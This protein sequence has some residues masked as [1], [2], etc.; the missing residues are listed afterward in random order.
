MNSSEPR[1]IW[2]SKLSFVLATAGAA[3]GLG[4]LWRFP[5]VAGEN[6][7]GAFVL[8]YIAFVVLLGVP[9]MMA[10]LAIGRRGGGS[11]V[12]S[13]RRLI[14]EEN[15]S[16]GWLAI[17]WLSLAVPLVGLSY[18]SVVA[19][20]SID[21]IAKAALNH[22]QQFNATDS[23]ASF[24]ALL[25]SPYHLLVLH[26]LFIAATVLVVARGVQG[27][28]EKVAKIMMPGLLVLLLIM[29]LNAIFA[30]DINGGLHFL[31][32][33]DFSKLTPTTIAVALGQAFFSIAVGVGVLMTYGSYMPKHFS[34]LGS[35]ATIITADTLVALLAGIAIFPVV[36]QY[37]LDPAGGPGLI[38]VTLPIAFGQMPLGHLLGFLFFILLFFAAFTTAIGM[39][40]PSVA[41]L[42]DRGYSR[43]KMA[44][45]AGAG[46]WFLG[47]AAVLS[48]N[49]WSGVRLTPGI[50]LLKD[51]DLFNL[52]DFVISN[53][54]LPLNALLIALFAG[55]VISRRS[56]L[57]ELQ[58]GEGIA[59]RYWR[60]SIRYIAPMAIAI[61]CF[62]SLS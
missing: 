6:G 24:D 2:S 18:Y 33:P 38:F 34:L 36:F 20:W 5:F 43:R 39:L 51:K 8:V 50:E 23:L 3:I 13:I 10:E 7:G 1:S 42:Q 40:E 11:A 53:I 41:W 14:K 57:D 9:I 58:I 49:L 17:G 55:W 28:I 52:I 15:A 45:V 62:T 27:G 4:N 35:A 44:I 29:V 37:G 25:A 19:G 54:S 56:S 16:R 22:F 32:N 21:Y 59:Y 26:T 30:A 31:F 60:V 48:F 47:L 61:V 12:H 46:A